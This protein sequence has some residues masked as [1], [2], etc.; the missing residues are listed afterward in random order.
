MRQYRIGWIVM[1]GV[2]AT[3]LSSCDSSARSAPSGVSDP[4]SSGAGADYE[5]SSDGPANT[6]SRDG[7]DPGGPGGSGSGSSDP[8]FAWVPFGPADPASPVP[9]DWPQYNML[10]QRRCGDLMQDENGPTDDQLW[11]ALNA[12]CAAV[13]DGDEEQW[14][15]ARTAFDN[16]GAQHFAN[17]CLENATRALLERALTW[18]EANPHGRPEV[19]FPVAA[20]ETDCG[21]L[22]KQGDEQEG[23]Q[24]SEPG[25]SNPSDQPGD[26]SP[27]SV[28][29]PSN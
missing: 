24:P 19:R 12:L 22:V 29:T 25:D 8:G 10:A 17:P 20:N 3:L 28:T 5:S 13:V 6:S 7:P 15:V 14:R 26:S 16:A 21:K 23:E 2:V 18:R 4:P 9:G 1:V 11:R 27:P